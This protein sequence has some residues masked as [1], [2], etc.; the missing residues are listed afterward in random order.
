MLENGY[1]HIELVSKKNRWFIKMNGVSQDSLFSPLL[2]NIYTND[3]P[4]SEG[5]CHFIYADDLALAG[6]DR[7]ISIVE[8]RFSNNLDELTPYHE[9]NYPHTNSSK[10]GVCHPL[11]E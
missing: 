4:R 9:E 11:T 1:F 10:I 6:Q 3:Q 8:E 7:K 2:F 5:T